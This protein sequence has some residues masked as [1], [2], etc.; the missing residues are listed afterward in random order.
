MLAAKAAPA[1]TVPAF[2]ELAAA[3]RLGLFAHGEDFLV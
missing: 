2:E 3:V 1:A